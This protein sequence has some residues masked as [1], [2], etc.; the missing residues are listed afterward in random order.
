MHQEAN[1]QTDQSRMAQHFEIKGATLWRSNVIEGVPTSISTDRVAV[2]TTF[3]QSIRSCDLR[4]HYAVV[5]KAK[6]SE[7]LKDAPYGIAYNYFAGQLLC[8]ACKEHF[9]GPLAITVDQ[10]N[11]ET[12]TKLKFDGYLETRL[13]IDCDH[14]DALTINHEESQKVRALQAADLISWAIFRNYEHADDRF[15]NV[16]RQRLGCCDDWYSWKK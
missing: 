12:H 4:I 9:A 2:L 10:R 7:K 14:R 5:N 16:L 8:R 1:G 3:L 11:K 13:V 15:L 6:L